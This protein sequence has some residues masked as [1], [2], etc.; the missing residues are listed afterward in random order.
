MPSTP[1]DARFL[2]PEERTQ[3]MNRLREDSHGATN[4]EDVNDEHFSWHWVRMA[5]LAPQTYLCALAWIFL[6]IPLYICLLSTARSAD[7][8]SNLFPNRASRCSSPQLY[9]A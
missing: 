6:L 2:T 8:H 1:A 7:H 9:K 4:V 5:V 3:A